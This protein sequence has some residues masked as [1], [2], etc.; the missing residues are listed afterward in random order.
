MNAIKG[1]ST[2]ILHVC[3]VLLFGLPGISHAQTGY[4]DV[5]IFGDSLSDAG[6]IYLLTGESSK[7]PYALVPTFPYTIGG[8]HYSNGKTWAEKLAQNLSDGTGGQASRANPGKNGNYAHGG[9]RARNNTMHPAPDSLDQVDM[10]IG[11]YGTASADALYVVQFGGNDLR[12]ALAAVTF[13]S[14]GNLDLSGSF[15]IIFAAVGEL[16]WTIQRLYDE[17]ARNFLV[18]NAP[19]LV[20]TPAVKLAGAELLA[21]FFTATYNGGLE[22]RLLALEANPG[23]TIYRLSISD[24]TDDVV[25]NPGDFG[26]SNVVAP[27][28]NFL[29]ESGGKCENPEDY[30]FWDGLH[31]TKAAHKQLADRA[32][33][34]LN[35]S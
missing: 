26:L 18:A 7:A 30:L 27:C 2:C 9:G 14:N 32:L 24:F 35:G 29:V 33:D 10:F 11:D 1:L 6:N 28:L 13:D 25:A 21:G 12:D 3:A 17:G 23:I 34:V 8:H 19:N 20:H 16:Q 22:G 4:G 31:P 15:A 5:F